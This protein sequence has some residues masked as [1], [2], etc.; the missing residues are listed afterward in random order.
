M[1]ANITLYYINYIYMKKMYKLLII[2]NEDESE[3]ETLVEFYD[4][5]ND[6]DLDV[7][8]T[9]DLLSSDEFGNEDI[10]NELIKSNLMGE[11]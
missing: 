3:C 2:F 6:E 5:I 8:E 1:F 7:E 9:V 4:E 10:R 11:A